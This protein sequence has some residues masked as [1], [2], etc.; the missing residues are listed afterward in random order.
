MAAISFILL[1]SGGKN[2]YDNNFWQIISL[3]LYNVSYTLALY[4][5]FLFYIAT[6]EEM[7]THSPVKKF[8]AVKSI[9]FM[10]YWQSLCVCFFLCDL[11]YN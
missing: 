10:T 9:V 7:K 6:K 4:G 3:T 2:L 1:A 5:L 8:L 11:I